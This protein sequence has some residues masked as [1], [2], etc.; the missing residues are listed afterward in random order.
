MPRER[1]AQYNAIATFEDMPRARRAMLALENGGIDGEDISLL[2]RAA[3]EAADNLDPRER[4][5]RSTTDIAKAGA[6]GVAAGAGVGAVAGFLG[7]ALAFG[8]PGVGPVVD[9]AI[10]AATLG[11]AGTGA[12]IGGL[13]AGTA[14]IGQSE[15]WA[16][17]YQ[18]SIRARHVLVGVHTETKEQLDKAVKILGEHEAQRIDMLDAEGKRMT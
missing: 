9:S 5:A 18:E 1:L 16:D 14:A 7:G 3:A 8:I 10:W 6:V 11:S 17:S 4:D 15:S 13:V 12:A 2:G